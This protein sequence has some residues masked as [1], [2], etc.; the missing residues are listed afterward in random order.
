MN[1]RLNQVG[2][3]QRLRV[4]WL[5]AAVNLILAGN[6]SASAQEALNEMLADKLSLNSRAVRG[7]RHKTITILKK[8]WLDVPMGLEALRD[9]GLRMQSTLDADHRHAVHWGMT[10]ATY[11]F[12]GTVAAQAGRLLRLQS[13]VAAAQIQR[14]VRESHGERSTVSRATARVLRSFI[15][16]G[17]LTDTAAK[18]V[19]AQGEQRQ[20]EDAKVAAWL[21]EAMLHGQSSGTAGLTRLLHHPS[22][23]PYRLPHL[24]ASQ[25][26]ANSTGLE[27]LR[28][29][30]DEEVLMLR[31]PQP[32]QAL[33]K[34][35][36]A[37]HERNFQ[38]EIKG[39]L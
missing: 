17:V 27:V 34:S 23:F 8:I 2:I 15:D 29:G 28:Q 26:A 25:L 4:E 16:W 39:H 12:W 9:A 5:E 3:S 33:P 1:D 30:L 10:L 14:R 20:I 37:M 38:A 24:A 32:T 11:P 21:A 6:D 31:A 7:N 35:R 19:Y 18:G 13:A 22:L 36:S